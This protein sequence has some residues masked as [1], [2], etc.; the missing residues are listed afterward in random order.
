MSHGV[1]ASSGRW[2]PRWSVEGQNAG[3]AASRAGLFGAIAIVGVGPPLLCSGA[4]NG[5]AFLSKWQVVPS[6]TLWP[7]GMTRLPPT[8]LLV[9]PPAVLPEMIEFRTVAGESATSRPP[10]PAA[11]VAELP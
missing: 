10:P 1:P 9:A 3:S 11:F 7:W 6:S 8:Q 5:L 4:S 2:T